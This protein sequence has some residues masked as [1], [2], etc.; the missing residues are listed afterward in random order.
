MLGPI[1]SKYII[2]FDSK[3]IIIVSCTWGWKDWQSTTITRVRLQINAFVDVL[4]TYIVLLA[5]NQS[6]HIIIIHVHSV[7]RW[8][9]DTEDG[10]K[11]DRRYWWA[12]PVWIQTAGSFPQRNEQISN[13]PDRAAWRSPGC[14]STPAHDDDNEKLENI[15]TR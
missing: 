2:I 9:A 4:F 13:W 6:C 7:N 8:T 12:D 5:W 15:I 1:V 11:A 10:Q 3:S 14:S